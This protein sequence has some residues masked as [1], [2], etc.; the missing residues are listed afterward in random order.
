MFKIKKVNFNKYTTILAI[1]GIG[2]VIMISILCFSPFSNDSAKISLNF[3]SEDEFYYLGEISDFLDSDNS[4]WGYNEWRDYVVLEAFNKTYDQL[5]DIIK[6][7]ETFQHNLH[8]LT[9]GYWGFENG[10]LTEDDLRELTSQLVHNTISIEITDFP[11]H[12]DENLIVKCTLKINNDFLI[13]YYAEAIW[14]GFQSTD[15]NGNWYDD[16]YLIVGEK[17]GVWYD[18]FPVDLTKGTA[19]VVQL[20]IPTH[21]VEDELNVIAVASYC[22]NSLTIQLTTTD[23]DSVDLVDDDTTGPGVDISYTGSSTDGNPG[24]WSISASDGLSSLDY[25]DISVDGTTIRYFPATGP[26]TLDVPVPKELGIHHI[27]VTAL[28][29]DKDRGDIDQEITTECETVTIVDDDISGPDIK[30]EYGEGTKTDGDPGYWIILASDFESGVAGYSVFIDGDP[31]ESEDG[32]FKVPNKLGTHQICVRALNDDTDRGSI[33]QEETEKCDY[34]TIVDDDTSSPII[35][36]EYVGSE[37]DGDPGGWNVYAMDPESDVANIIVK[38]DGDYAGEGAGFYAVSS[39]LGSHSIE[40]IATN[41][42]DDR[43]GDEEVSEK[44]DSIFISDDDLTAPNVEL[45]E[46]EMQWVGDDIAMTFHLYASD[47]SSI[48]DVRVRIEGIT[49]IG[50]AS[51]EIILAPGVYNAYLQA[52]DGDSD[53]PNDAITKYVQI[54]LYFDL[55]PPETSL[56][57]DPYFLN[58]QNQ[59]FVSSDTI[60]QLSA[61]DDVSGMAHCYYRING[62]VWVEYTHS[63]SLEGPDGNYIIDYYSID[64]QGNQEAMKSINVIL[65]TEAPYSEINYDPKFI[66]EE[67]IIFVSGIS[68]FYLTCSDDLSGV[69]TTYFSFDGVTFMEYLEPFILPSDSSTADIFYYAVD[70]LGNSETPVKQF[71]VTIDSNSPISTSD[72]DFFYDD[73]IGHFYITSNT[74]ISLSCIDDLLDGCEIFY[75]VNNSGWFLYEHPFHIDDMDGQ[76]IIEFYSVDAVM[77]QEEFNSFIVYLDNSSPITNIIMTPSKTEE[78]LIYVMGDTCYLL[79]ALDNGAGVSQVYYRIN[80]SEWILYDEP[81]NFTDTFT[82]LNIDYYSIDYV[83]NVE[84]Y[85]TVEVL[86]TEDYVEGFGILRINGETYCGDAF[87]FISSTTIM[88]EVEGATAS[89]EVVKERDFGCLEIYTAEGELGR[90]EVFVFTIRGLEYVLAIGNGVFFIY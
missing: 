3:S 43:P 76:Y 4:T 19:Y 90:I 39:E 60:F 70:N 2:I 56:S 81:F 53:R 57:Y 38:I 26:F 67:G 49:Y 42:D 33:D 48:S 88:M 64:H 63:F 25:V 86:Y 87:L 82:M 24:Y 34:I 18:L 16:D 50:K 20:T 17:L 6:S 36:L 83:G 15:P 65:D 73:D 1:V 14:I 44:S 46:D 47:S 13:N 52:T 37:T 22:V 8:I 85:K 59:I 69:S 40:V 21:S 89:W 74:F 23:T 28:N 27:C 71:S 62:G 54:T 77:N 79:E 72:L 68:E 7:N 12:T 55:N 45:I 5:D 66:D 31:A 75:R 35:L 29:D 61:I 30:I 41:G 78:D 11:T 9:I 58:D 32:K 10:S 80:G 51:H 84:V